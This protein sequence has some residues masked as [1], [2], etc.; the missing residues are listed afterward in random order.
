M[1]FVIKS[2][3]QIVFKG[4]FVKILIVIVTFPPYSAVSGSRV[5]KFAKYMDQNGHDVKVLAPL[6]T[7][8]GAALKPD[9]SSDKI[10]FTDFY[11]INTFP[12]QLKQIL[13][14]FFHQSRMLFLR[15]LLKNKIMMMIKMT[16]RQNR[17]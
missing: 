9:I 15:R 8:V 5:N 10:I 11:D 6:R 4:S 16:M 3:I 13:K 12:S 1:L 14:G 2:N 7:D 17:Q